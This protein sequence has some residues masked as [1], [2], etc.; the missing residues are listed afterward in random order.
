MKKKFLFILVL[1]LAM[2]PLRSEALWEEDDNIAHDARG[3]TYRREGNTIYKSDGTVYQQS[4]NTITG[5][6]GS[7]WQQSGDT[8]YRNGREECYEVNGRIVCN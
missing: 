8:Y 7:H 2:S 5:S 1:L 3:N 4:G 6:D